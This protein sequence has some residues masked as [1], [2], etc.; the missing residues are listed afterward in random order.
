MLRAEA[1]LDHLAHATDYANEEDEEMEVNLGDAS[2]GKQPLAGSQKPPVPTRLIITDNNAYE[3]EF[4]AVTQ[5]RNQEGSEDSDD[6]GSGGG[7]HDLR[8]RRRR[9]RTPSLKERGRYLSLASTLS[10]PSQGF[11]PRTG[12]PAT[13]TRRSISGGRSDVYAS[14][15]GG[16]LASP[17]ARAYSQAQR[18]L[19]VV[20]GSGNS[21]NYVGAGGAG[22]ASNDDVLAAVKRLEASI[23]AANVSKGNDEEEGKGTGNQSKG[24]VGTDADVLRELGER[25][26]R[27]EALLLSLTREMRS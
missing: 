12:I 9:D 11:R 24:Q 1:D 26:T 2:A 21:Q 7:A 8:A 22:G 14:G 17:L 27:I 23:A 19:S 4:P 15:P 25:Q 13:S 6:N 20:A 16:V 10:Q 3:E 18:P 5:R